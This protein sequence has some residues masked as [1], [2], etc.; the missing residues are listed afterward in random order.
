MKTIESSEERSERILHYRSELSIQLRLRS[1]IYNSNLFNVYVTQDKSR[2][3]LFVTITL[4]LLIVHIFLSR[5]FPCSM[6]DNHRAKNTVSALQSRASWMQWSSQSKI[7]TSLYRISLI[8]RAE[9]EWWIA[10]KQHRH[11]VRVY[12]SV[13][14]WIEAIDS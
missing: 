11:A 5:I 3:E 4:Y 10:K 2:I 7:K 12:S 9:Q 1:H 14:C 6:N 8:W 13:T